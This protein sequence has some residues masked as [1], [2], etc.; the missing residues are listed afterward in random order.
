V[1]AIYAHDSQSMFTVDNDTRYWAFAEAG[2]GG[3]PWGDPAPAGS[4]AILER[5]GRDGFYR[6]ERLDN[7]F[8]DDETPEGRSL[9]RL[10]GPGRTIG[11]IEVCKA[12]EF[13]KVRGILDTTAATTSAVDSKTLFGRLTG[14]KET[15]RKFGTM[16]VL[17]SGSKLNYDSKTGVVSITRTE[18]GSR[19]QRST[20][21]CTVQKDG[22][23]KK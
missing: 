4:Y 7:R 15:L 3:K 20:T 17:P 16:N 13:R 1:E 23:C 9:L 2:S 12:D 6:L 8:G 10:H 21:V 5:G 18:T 19:I 22:S 11:C 14:E